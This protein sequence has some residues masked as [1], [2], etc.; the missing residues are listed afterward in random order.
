MM[1]DSTDFMEGFIAAARTFGLDL[2]AT[3]ERV[4]VHCRPLAAETSLWAGTHLTMDDYLAIPTFIRQGRG[5]QACI[6]T[7]FIDK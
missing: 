7:G 5:V 2:A 1:L 6:A 3:P 4:L